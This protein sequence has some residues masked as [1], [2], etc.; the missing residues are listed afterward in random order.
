VFVLGLDTATEAVAVDV[1]EL[2]SDGAVRVLAGRAPVNARGHGELLTPTIADCLTAAGIGAGQLGA[3]VAGVGPGPY[4]GLRVGLVTAAAL[5]HALDVPTYGVCSLD[6]VAGRR[7]DLADLLVATD[8]RRHEVYW[9][10]YE[11]GRRVAGPDVGP[12]AGLALDAHTHR[13]GA[14]VRRYADVLGPAEPDLDYPSPAALVA[15]AAGRVLAAEPGERGEVLTPLYLR[16]PDAV[17]PGAPK[18]VSQ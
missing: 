9:A 16:H 10:R 8:A 3:V 2:G 11:R 5:G 7:P 6:G 1:V 13:A 14:G 12:P 18:P 17:V 15:A 4:T